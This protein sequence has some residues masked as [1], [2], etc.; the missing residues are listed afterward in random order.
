L[1]LV[2]VLFCAK[3]ITL[4]RLFAS[5]EAVQRAVQAEKPVRAGMG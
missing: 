2:D 3:E 5:G 4:D 1:R